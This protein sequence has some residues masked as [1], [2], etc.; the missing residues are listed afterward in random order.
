MKEI[1]YKGQNFIQSEANT[2][3]GQTKEINYE[4][5]SFTQPE[6]STVEE[7]TLREFSG[8]DHFLLG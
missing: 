3:E 8:I 5:Q 7:Q 6:A 2:A 1:N 4:E